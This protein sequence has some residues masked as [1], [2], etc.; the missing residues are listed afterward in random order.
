MARKDNPHVSY[1][2]VEK[3]FR[4]GN[5]KLDD[6]MPDMP[7]DTSSLP[8]HRVH[9]LPRQ[10][11]PNL[12]RPPV[13]NKATK[14]NLLDEK[15]FPVQGGEKQLPGDVNEKTSTANIS[16]RK[17][18]VFHDDDVE[19]DSSKLK[20]KPNL[21]FKTRTN[22]TQSSKE[23]TLLKKPE[24]IQVP[25]KPLEE[26]VTRDNSV[27][28]SSMSMEGLEVEDTFNGAGCEDVISQ[29]SCDRSANNDITAVRDKKGEGTADGNYDFSQKAS[30]LDG[31][32]LI[33]N[34][35]VS[36]VG[37]FICTLEG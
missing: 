34:D 35:V 25:S 30:E 15:P 11:K 12:S 36:S 17:P 18:F 26:R 23:V 29:N 33:G 9:D 6:I 22:P 32:L 16:L 1:L 21:F 37:L 24:A 7:L 10:S 19:A 20:I 5:G 8:S 31:G 27:D 2:D 14:S 28:M 4:K 3:S 13:M